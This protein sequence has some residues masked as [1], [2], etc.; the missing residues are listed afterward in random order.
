MDIKTVQ[1]IAAYIYE[2]L[3]KL[4]SALVKKQNI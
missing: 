4:C 1:S 2:A 3:L